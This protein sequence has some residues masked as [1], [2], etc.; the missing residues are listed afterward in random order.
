MERKELIGKRALVCFRE[1]SR[2]AQV[3]GIIAGFDDFFVSVLTDENY[4]ILPNTA[5][6]KIKVRRADIN[7]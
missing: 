7:V 2:N 5:L 4:L 3:F 1:A 6:E